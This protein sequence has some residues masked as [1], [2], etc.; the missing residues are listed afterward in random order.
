MKTI[1][2]KLILI[3]LIIFPII[4]LPQ[5][6]G[7]IEIIEDIADDNTLIRLETDSGMVIS[8]SII[9]FGLNPN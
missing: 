3:I 2:K 9:R 6:N 7:I 4:C 5:S 8:E 1:Y